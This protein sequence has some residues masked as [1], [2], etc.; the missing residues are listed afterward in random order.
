MILVEC[1]PDE[2]LVRILTGSHTVIHCGNKSGVCR[3]LSKKYR[4]AIGLIDHDPGSA[5]PV[6]IKN[7]IR[8]NNARRIDNITI[9]YDPARD[10]YIIMLYPHLEGWILDSAKKAG[11]KPDKYNLPNDEDMLHKEI[12]T[13]T[14][15]FERLLQELVTKSQKLALLREILEKPREHY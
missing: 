4:G 9:L 7:L 6:Y 2:A 10:N 13:R 5:Q 3:M 11:V 15:N 1:K 8:N 12:N 14:Q